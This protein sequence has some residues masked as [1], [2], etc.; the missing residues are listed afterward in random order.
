[1]DSYWVIVPCWIAISSSLFIPM[2]L[3]SNPFLC[4]EVFY[5]ILFAAASILYVKQS[6]EIFLQNL[7]LVKTENQAVSLQSNAMML[8]TRMNDMRLLLGN[9]AH[10]LKTPVSV[11]DCVYPLN[12]SVTVF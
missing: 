12:I 6:K 9:I 2:I 1:L 11:I 3:N 4:D 5:L 8:E 7:Q 10:D